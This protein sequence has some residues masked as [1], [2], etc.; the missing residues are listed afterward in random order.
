MQTKTKIAFMLVAPLLIS[1]CI[2]LHPGRE[3][4]FSVKGRVISNKVPAAGCRLG[5]YLTKGDVKIREVSVPSE[6]K[7]PSLSCQ[8]FM[9][10]TCWYIA[11][12]IRHTEV[13]HI[14]WAGTT[15]FCTQSI[16]GKLIW[17]GQTRL[18]RLES[19]LLGAAAWSRGSRPLAS[20]TVLNM[21][22]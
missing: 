3:S 13:S 16:W 6:F 1:G 9:N 15:I 11:Q 18:A 8:G 7:Q 12:E 21:G 5:V 14:G 20:S 17:H 22:T 2:A 4:G 10:T 19:L